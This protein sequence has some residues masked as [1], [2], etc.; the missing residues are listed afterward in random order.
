MAAKVRADAV[1][2]SV[3]AGQ[4]TLHMKAPYIWPNVISLLQG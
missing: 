1:A 4:R 2:V 3:E